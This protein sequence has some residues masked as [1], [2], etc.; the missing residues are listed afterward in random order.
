MNDVPDEAKERYY[1]EVSSNLR[2][3]GYGVSRGDEGL[4]CVEYNGQHLCRVNGAGGVQYRL[5]DV[6]ACD[7]GDALHKV[8]NITGVTAEYMGAMEAAPFLKA[9]G[10]DDKWKLISEYKDTVLAG[11]T[12][13]YGAEFATWERT[14]DGKGVTIG[15]YFTDYEKSKQDF[16][17]RSGLFPRERAFTDEQLTDLYLSA[18]WALEN[19]GYMKFDDYRRVRETL[20]QIERLLPQVQEQAMQ[21]QY[22]SIAE[23]TM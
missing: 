7:G 20:E 21:Q 5:G 16:A 11:H 12:T 1:A 13:S 15:H 2:K 9:E 19:N 8:I 17:V 6:E 14:Y 22:N 23:Q 4:L 3:A 10:L 18:S